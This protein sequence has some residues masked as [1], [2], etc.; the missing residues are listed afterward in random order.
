M[1]EGLAHQLRID[2]PK[3]TPGLNELVEAVQASGAKIAIQIN[4]QGA[5]VDPELQAEVQPVGPSAISYVFDQTGPGSALPPRMRRVK[6]LRALTVEEMKELRASFIR[7]SG[8]AKSAGFDASEI[9][10][11]HV[12]PPFKRDLGGVSCLPQ[13]SS[14]EKSRG[15][16]TARG[17]RRR[18]AES[19]F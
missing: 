3:L 5:G 12:T 8:I 18:S 15:R 14:R 19:K 2:D 6:H 13:R 10:G 17:P 11:A 1:A 4:I 9:H 16:I 7:A